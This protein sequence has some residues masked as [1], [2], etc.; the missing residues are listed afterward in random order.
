MAQ[1]EYKCIEPAKCTFQE[2]ERIFNELG[3]DGWELI[4]GKGGQFVFKRKLS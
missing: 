4:T 1:W 2:I 3:V